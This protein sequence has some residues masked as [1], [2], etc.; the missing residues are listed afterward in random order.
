MTPFFS[1][2]DV[3]PFMDLETAVGVM[4]EDIEGQHSQRK[5]TFRQGFLSV[6]FSQ[7]V[8]AMLDARMNGL[9]I[10]PSR[11]ASMSQ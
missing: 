11:L 7:E 10:V 3:A 8:L 4:T 5:L 2:L 6:F 9:R 1:I